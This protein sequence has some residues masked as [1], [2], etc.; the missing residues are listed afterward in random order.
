MTAL[1]CS[2]CCTIPTTRTMGGSALAGPGAAAGTA[3]G[4]GAERPHPHPN[5]PRPCALGPA[6]STGACCC[7]CVVAG[8]E[9]DAAGEAE[10]EEEE[11]EAGPCAAGGS[12]G[13]GRAS[14]AAA[15]ASMSS[16]HDAGTQP[17]FTSTA[18]CLRAVETRL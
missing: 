12:L 5:Q 4:R 18:P 14:H 15:T 9:E 3:A 11:G 17:R 13:C 1:G 6:P 16:F 2:L 10:A 7:C 8:P